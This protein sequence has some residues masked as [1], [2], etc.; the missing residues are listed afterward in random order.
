MVIIGV[1]QAKVMSCESMPMLLDGMKDSAYNKNKH[2]PDRRE[3]ILQR[4]CEKCSQNWLKPLR[5]ELPSGSQHLSDRTER[6]E[7]QEKNGKL[8]FTQQSGRYSAAAV[9]LNL[10]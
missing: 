3:T 2:T 8:W 6:Q 5:S 9:S 7:L 10:S 4:K 1:L